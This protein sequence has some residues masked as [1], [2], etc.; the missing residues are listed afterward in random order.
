V[1]PKSEVLFSQSRDF[2][3]LD[4]YIRKQEKFEHL[5]ESASEKY[6]ASRH[7]IA[8]NAYGKIAALEVQVKVKEKE[9]NSFKIAS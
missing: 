3:A 7:D 9:S 4:E 8:E 6:I 5:L 2:T 1:L